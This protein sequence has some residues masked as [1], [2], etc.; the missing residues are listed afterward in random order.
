[1]CKLAVIDSSI[2]SQGNASTD[3]KSRNL[4]RKVRRRSLGFSEN[5]FNTW[6]PSSQLHVFSRQAQSSATLSLLFRKRLLRNRRGV[7]KDRRVVTISKSWIC[8]IKTFVDKGKRTVPPLAIGKSLYMSTFIF[9]GKAD[10]KKMPNSSSPLRAHSQ[11]S[12]S[13]YSI[14]SSSPKM[15]PDA[16]STD[17]PG[18]NGRWKHVLIHSPLLQKQ[19]YLISSRSK[20]KVS[21]IMLFPCLFL[22]PC[23]YSHGK[24]KEA[25]SRHL[26]SVFRS[27]TNCLESLP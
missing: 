12:L 24:V 4:R 13:K 20:A 25:I 17:D 10:L 14:F 6:R 26:E 8:G 1:M 16:W 3:S 21:H 7:F 11:Q 23:S 5:A 19:R 22:C 9:Y 2:K 27:G 15:I 18:G